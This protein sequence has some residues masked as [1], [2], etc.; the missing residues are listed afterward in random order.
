[1][2]LPSI[3]STPRPIGRGRGWVSFLR[4]EGPGVV[5]NGRRGRVLLFFVLI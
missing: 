2:P 1:M 5:D 3:Q 4:K